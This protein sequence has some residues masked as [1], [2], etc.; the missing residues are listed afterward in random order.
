M[1]CYVQNITNYF[2]SLWIFLRKFRNC[3]N[4]IIYFL[5]NKHMNQ[6]EGVE[7]SVACSLTM[8]V[9]S[10]H[11]LEMT[12]AWYS[13]LLEICKSNHGQSIK[14]YRII[15]LMRMGG[16]QVTSPVAKHYISITVFEFPDKTITQP[17]CGETAHLAT[18]RR[19][20]LFLQLCTRSIVC[21]PKS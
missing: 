17:V 13:K 2:H 8:E 19:Y 9:I 1:F 11:W 10:V 4:G 5:T 3:C 7:G 21:W 6:K 14:L 20:A 15:W 18:V 16:V 12:V